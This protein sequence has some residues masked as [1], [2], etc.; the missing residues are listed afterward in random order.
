MRSTSS[1]MRTSSSSEVPTISGR[2]L[3]DSHRERQSELKAARALA[4]PA[5]SGF[6]NTVTSNWSCGSPSSLLPVSK[7]Q[8]KRGARRGALPVFYFGAF[9]LD[10]ANLN[11]AFVVSCGVVSSQGG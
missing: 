11:D 4:S 7:E 6:H 5:F 1:T 2:G 9:H 10:R 8:F 3:R